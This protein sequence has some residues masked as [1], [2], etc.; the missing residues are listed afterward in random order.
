M[1]WFLLL[2]ALPLAAQNALY[3]DLSGPWH[4]LA[5][6]NPAYAARDFDDR[7]WTTVNTP[8]SSAARGQ[9]WMRRRADLPPGTDRSRLALTLGALAS[10]YEVYVN[11]ERIGATDGFDHLENAHLRQPRTFAI[12]AGAAMRGQ[13]P[14]LQIAVRARQAGAPLAWAI[15]DRG[16]W[17]LS[18]RD[19][20]PLIGAVEQFHQRAVENSPE[21]VF[22][23]I[24]WGI[25]LLSLMAWGNDRGRVELL[26]FALFALASGWLRFVTFFGLNPN[27][28]GST[29]FAMVPLLLSLALMGEFVMA[30]A[31]T[32]HLGRWRTV[33]W[34]G[35]GIGLSR[36]FFPNGPWQTAVA[37]GIASI[38]L[39]AVGLVAWRRSL[40][41]TGP[42][43]D[44]VLWLTILF[45]G[46][47]GLED[48]V[49]R[50][51]LNAPN[52]VPLLFQLGGY[53]VDRRVALAVALAAVILATLLARLMADRREKERLASE[54][55]A[56]GVI[57]R[58]LLDKAALSQPGLTLDAVYAP[59]QE[60]GG[61]F[62]YV[63]DGQLVVVGDV[64]GKGL[65]AAMLVSLVIG[66]LRM[67]ASH[68]PGEVLAALNRAVAGQADGGFV[69][70]ACARFDSDG[71]VTVANAGH[72]PPYLNGAEAEVET[73]LPLGLV[74]GAL[75]A[76]S[77]LALAPGESITF[78]SDG[79]V[80]AAN[81]PG[82]LFGF[83]R[84]REIAG[85]SAQEIA[86]A[87]QA[88]GQNDDITVVTVRRME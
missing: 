25:A 54:F 10:A 7:Q 51:M 74:P 17:A 33:L 79:V 84:T 82:E 80:E 39:I 75:Y 46:F 78:L 48:F 44:R 20:L 76:E 85:K 4:M 21:L 52:F 61:D 16:P 59:A 69:T 24:L 64:S 8:L 63:L 2:L 62:Y 47:L 41:E 56:A 23:T 55:Q 70:C 26:W 71:V 13:E 43:Q 31:K 67:I 19:Q 88:W 86:A 58:L 29:A 77:T 12:P 45:Q 27:Q 32:S 3:L 83:E 50:R 72:L 38:L 1:N 66:A 49:L 73:G 15:P 18:Y 14:S 35:F 30:A 87:A 22:G 11:G 5:G 9:F 81:A 36:V 57:Q 40:A 34:G 28:I 6:D 37:E 60:V 65:K 42:W 53:E 68:R